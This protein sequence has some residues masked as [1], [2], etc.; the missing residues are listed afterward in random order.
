MSSSLRSAPSA[1]DSRTGPP[2][3]M[4]TAMGRARRSLSAR[5]GAFLLAGMLVLGIPSP[6]LAA[7][8][9]PKLERRLL[10]LANRARDNHGLAPLRM[11]PGMRK[12]ARKHSLHMARRQTLFHVDCLSCVSPKPYRALGENVAMGTKLRR[13]HRALMRSRSHRRNILCGCF[14]RAGTGVARGGGRIWV[15]QRFW[16]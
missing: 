8:G 6:A 13:I 2:G 11:G 3:P 9:A 15:T 16:G 4:V 5:W 1:T 14:K 12:K 7:K 10:V